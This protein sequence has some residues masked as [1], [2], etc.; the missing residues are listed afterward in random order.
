MKDEIINAMAKDMN[1]AEFSDESETEYTNRIL[2][3]ALASWIKAS[4]LDRSVGNEHEPNAGVSKRHITEKCERFLEE[5]L[6]RHPKCKSWFTF[7]KQDSPISLIR[8]RLLRNGE[9]LN[10]GF[11][12]NVILSQAETI[13]LCNNLSRYKGVVLKP[14]AQYSGISV[15]GEK[16]NHDTI[17]YSHIEDTLLWFRNYIHQAWWSKFENNNDSVSYFNPFEKVRS[18]SRCW[19]SSKPRYVNDI[20]LARRT[21]NQV[22]HEYFF[23]RRVDEGEMFHRIDPFIKTIG[24]HRRFMIAIRNLAGNK[25]AAKVCVHR[26]YVG[27]ITWSYLPQQEATLLESFAWPSN[28]YSDMI[29]WK[30]TIGIYNYIKPFLTALGIELQEEHNG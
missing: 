4:A 14:D 24:E 27:L 25:N 29:N 30:M 5:M 13:P 1:I 28:N 22:N 10:V 16:S 20:I 23:L 21:A 15:I 26:D 9:L 17:G 19:Q 8:S 12:S 6:I 11:D 18:N 3:S 2:Y 7:E